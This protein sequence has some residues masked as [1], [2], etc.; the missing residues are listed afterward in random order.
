VRPEASA[1]EFAAAVER[2]YARDDVDSVVA[3]FMPPLVTPGQDVAAAV[4]AAQQRYGKTTV[5]T[6]LGIRGVPEQ[7]R[8]TPDGALPP[9]GSV[10]SYP[11]PE[12][13]VRALVAASRYA[14][15]RRRPRGQ[16][17]E[18]PDTDL[19][20]ARKLVERRLGE[21]ASEDGIVRLA[22]ED[23][24]H[25]LG[26]FG[27]RVEP[28]VFVSSVGEAVAAARRLGYPV[29]LKT[30]VP[31]LR[32]RPD[33]ADVKLDLGDSSALVRAWSELRATLGEDAVRDAILQRMAP[34]GV[35]VVVQALEDPLFGPTVS[36]GVGGVAS[37][38]LGDRSYRFPPLTDNDVTDMIR[39]V[40]ALPLLTGH[41]GSMPVDLDAVAE[42]ISR[43]AALKDALPEVVELALDPVLVS[44]QGLTVL[45]AVVRLARPSVRE[46]V[47]PRRLA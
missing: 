22:Y 42:L 8:G 37:E 6:F 24:E 32:S 39:G 25:L 41:R 16:V 46:D 28:T 34:V 19:A 31:A 13:A 27:V 45:R 30:A 17:P 26:C 9:F 23:A 5:A 3:V 29:V 7:L 4:A 35:P 43:V 40:K 2:A 47:G 12:E 44:Q 38:V 33:L 20:G 10:P 11:T 18:L 36:F 15:W 14:A 1:D 21:G